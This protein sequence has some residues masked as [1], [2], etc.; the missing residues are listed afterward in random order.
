MPN[1]ENLVQ[2]GRVVGFD[3]ANPDFCRITNGVFTITAYIPFKNPVVAIGKSYTVYKSGN[4]YMVGTEV[5]T[6]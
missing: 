6:L 4:T 3:R 2:F 5:Q 1:T